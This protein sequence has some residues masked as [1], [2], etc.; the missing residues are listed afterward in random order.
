MDKVPVESPFPIKDRRK[1]N[2]QTYTIP[3][4]LM[5]EEVESH[6]FSIDISTGGI[7][8]FSRIPLEFA[9]AYELDLFLEGFPHP[10]RVKGKLAWQ[11]K[12]NI[13]D[14]LH[15]V[16]LVF[17][18]ISAEH[19]QVLQDYAKKWLGTDRTERRKFLRVPRLLEADVVQESKEATISGYVLDISEL[20]ARFL[21]PLLLEE[22]S[23]VVLKVELAEGITTSI[24]GRVAW[25]KPSESIGEVLRG[26]KA[27]H[28]IKFQV[29]SVELQ[30]F[31]NSYVKFQ[32]ESTQTALVEVLLNLVPS[33]Q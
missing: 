22:K 33:E 25:G 21:S 23:T 18:E 8:L 4:R 5:G 10:V 24:S 3:V 29:H 13:Q 28:G 7:R 2:R 31:L 6:F 1:S 30:A 11:R 15:E 27:V 26:M 32:N 20:G 12:L 17:S 16:A 19:R 9:Q 14:Q